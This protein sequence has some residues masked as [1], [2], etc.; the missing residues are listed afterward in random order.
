MNE[1]ATINSCQFMLVVIAQGAVHLSLR[2]WPTEE[3]NYGKG[4][5]EKR[6]RRKSRKKSVQKMRNN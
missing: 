1:I 6:T 4:N 5:G 3:W 2:N